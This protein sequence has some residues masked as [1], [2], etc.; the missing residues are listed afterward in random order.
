MSQDASSR[1]GSPPP[2]SGST[3]STPNSTLQAENNAPARLLPFSN[4][5]LVFSLGVLLVFLT[6]WILPRWQIAHLNLKGV[7]K[8]TT[9]NTLR[10]TWAKILATIFFLV[11]AYFTW[12]YVEAMGRAVAAAERTVAAAEKSA[13]IGQER[14]ITERFVRVME[15]LGDEKLEV[16]LGGIYALERIARDSPKDQS[17]VTEVLATYVREHAP[18][19]LSTSQ[20]QRIRADVQ[21]ILTV[22]GRRTWAEAEEQSLDLHETTLSTAYLPFASFQRAYLYE[23]N[24]R[25]AMLYRAN[26]QGA[27]LWKAQLHN[28]ILEGAHLE[29]ADLTAAEGMTWEQ[30]GQAHIDPSTKLPDYL[31]ASIP[32]NAFEPKTDKEDEE[33]P[34]LDGFQADNQKLPTKISS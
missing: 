31:R 34:A 23:A 6:L 20:P 11:A 10:D 16:R 18:L 29:S 12:R 30:L 17:A 2:S 22:L 4:R 33:V 9:E 14:H 8:V 13:A 24:L 26:L 7:E 3:P 27:W 5:W 28:A 21:A 1:P 15:L 25:G 19:N 32:D